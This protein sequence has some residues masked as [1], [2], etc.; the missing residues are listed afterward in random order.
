MKKLLDT[1]KMGNM[2]LKNRFISAAIGDF[3]GEGLINERIIEK[4]ETLAKGGVGTIITGFTLVDE[5]EKSFPILSIYEDS[6]IENFKKLTDKIHSHGANFISQLVYIG[7][8]VMGDVGD[9]EIL[10]PSAVANPNTNVIPKEM[11]IS[12]IKAVQQKF[13]EAALRAKKSGFDGIEIHAA[14]GFLLNQFITPY[15]NRRNDIY[16]GSIENRVRMLLE[17]YSAIR[18]AVGPEYPIWVKVNSIEGFEGGLTLEDCLYTCKELTK[19][20]VNAIEVSGNFMSLSSNKGIYF[21]EE[22]AAIAKENNVAVIVTGGNRNFEEMEKL[23]SSTRIEYFGMARPFIS[24]PDLIN[25]YEKE[26]ITQTKCVSCNQCANPSNGFR[27][28]LNK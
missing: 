19:L 11:N 16:G 17:T 18:E 13:A 20:G 2:T 21:K 4:Y 14:H 1:T 23:L 9:R 8:Y 5:A 22:A 27:C 3:T 28:V 10:G 7:S 24:E 6:F 26:H 12:E 15:Y 25:K